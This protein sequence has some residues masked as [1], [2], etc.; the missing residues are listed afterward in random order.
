MNRDNISFLNNGIKNGDN[1]FGFVVKAI[2]LS[3]VTLCWHTH[4]PNWSQQHKKFLV[5]MTMAEKN[6]N[7]CFSLIALAA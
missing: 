3:S 1:G 7:L 6:Q 4:G 2:Q 5:T